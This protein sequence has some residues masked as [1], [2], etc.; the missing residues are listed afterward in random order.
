[1]NLY[2]GTI[3]ERVGRSFYSASME[4]LEWNLYGASVQEPL[5]GS[6]CTGALRSFYRGASMELLWTSLYAG[7]SIEKPLCRSLYSEASKQE[8][9]WRSPYGGASTEEP[10]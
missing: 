1:M 5:W 2:V 6:L 10:L 9:L 7:A 3:E 8:P 4:P